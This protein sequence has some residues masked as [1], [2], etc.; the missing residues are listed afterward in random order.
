LDQLEVASED[1]LSELVTELHEEELTSRYIRRDEAPFLIKD[2]AGL[3]NWLRD[4]IRDRLSQQN[5]SEP[6]TESR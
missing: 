1:D 5:N 6:D 4:T 2:E 3:L